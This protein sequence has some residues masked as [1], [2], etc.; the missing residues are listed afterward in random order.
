M[1][2]ILLTHSEQDQEVARQLAAFLE[3]QGRT[4]W[5]GQAGDASMAEHASAR[6][7]IAIW[8]KASLASPLLLQQAIAA[9]DAEKLLQVTS[10]VQ[11]R[12]VPLRQD[13]PLFD[14]SDFL[15]ISLAVMPYCRSP[16]R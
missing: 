13:G 2:D 4:V 15:Q 1:T 9:R 11:Q 10:Q 7:V 14:V 16:K 3:G 5:C 6:V 12:E 8:S